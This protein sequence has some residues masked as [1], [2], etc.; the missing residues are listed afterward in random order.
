M[1]RVA[2]L[3]LTPR[4]G[5][6]KLVIASGHQARKEAPSENDQEGSSTTGTRM[7]DAFDHFL[8]LSRIFASRFP[9]SDR[10]IFAPQ[11]GQTP[12]GTLSI[13]TNFPR[14]QKSCLIRFPISFASQ[15]SHSP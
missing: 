6:Q 2:P 11:R 8:G 13:T 1:L 10:T 12:A 14:I 4:L 7:T 9:T 15:I 3:D 5:D